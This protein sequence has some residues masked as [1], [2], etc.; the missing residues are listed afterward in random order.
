MDSTQ[1]LSAY[2]CSA[3]LLGQTGSLLF[4]QVPNIP[5]T[6]YTRILL[7]FFASYTRARA[8]ARTHTHTL[9]LLS[10]I[11]Q[12][13]CHNT[14]TLAFTLTHSELMHA[15]SLCYELTDATE[16]MTHGVAFLFLVGFF[17]FCFV[18]WWCIRGGGGGGGGERFQ[19]Q[20]EGLPLSTSRKTARYVIHNLHA[21][22]HEL[23]YLR[24]RHCLV[25]S[26]VP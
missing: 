3:L 25:S 4:L 21:C 13:W 5:Y 8:R 24:T 15:R 14:H 17:C 10:F 16:I 26:L 7:S 9:V 18:P 1:S 19:Y 12:R 2:Q 20:H 11:C 6:L 22:R 23:M